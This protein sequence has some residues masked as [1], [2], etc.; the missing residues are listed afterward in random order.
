LT[1]V[2]KGRYRTS[3]GPSKHLPLENKIFNI[4]VIIDD[5]KDN[6]LRKWS[7]AETV[8]PA[9]AMYPWV[10]PGQSYYC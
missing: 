1:A 6:M 5:S 2:P 4:I 9:L 3:H 10:R 8:S 7:K